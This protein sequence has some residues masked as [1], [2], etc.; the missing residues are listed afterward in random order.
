MLTDGDVTRLSYFVTA[1]ANSDDVE[2]ITARCWMRSTVG[3]QRT[4]DLS[5]G[6]AVVVT[7]AVFQGRKPVVNANVSVSVTGSGGVD[8]GSFHLLDNGAGADLVA[9]DGL[10]SAYFI[11]AG[12][13][14]GEY[15]FRCRI[16]GWEPSAHYEEGE[17]S[18]HTTKVI[19]AAM[20]SS[21]VSNTT[22]P[23]CC[24]GDAWRSDA[25]ANATGNFT[26]EYAVFGAI[27]VTG[28]VEGMDTVAPNKVTDLHVAVSEEDA[29][30]SVIVS[31]TA[32]GNDSTNGKGK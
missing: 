14:N 10:Y 30:N 9:N 11:P 22:S 15:S 25:T 17:S 18:W 2:P 27:V 7:S 28:L 16:E 31:F 29:A 3:N 5:A 1:K 20:D 4:A 19:N 23:I 6:D 32:P 21:A 13:A 24:G 12:Q 26:R 8:G